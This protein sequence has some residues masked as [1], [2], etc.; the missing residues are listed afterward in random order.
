MIFNPSRPDPGPR[1]KI[2]IN[3]IF[4]LFCGTTKGF[5]NALKAF[6]KPFEAP[7]RSVKIK[8]KLIFISTQ[9]SEMHGA[10]RVKKDERYQLSNFAWVH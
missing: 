7:R 3:F 9:L 5:M 8:L 1:E 6:I 2:N 10:G 4:T